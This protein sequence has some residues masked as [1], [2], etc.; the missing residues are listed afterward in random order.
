MKVKGNVE[1]LVTLGDKDHKKIVKQSF[2]V[3]K[4]DALCNAIFS[5][6]LMNKLNIIMSP[7][8]LLMKFETDKGIDLSKVTKLR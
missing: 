6:P 5:K 8:S 7:K 1:L 4:I 2:M 3:A